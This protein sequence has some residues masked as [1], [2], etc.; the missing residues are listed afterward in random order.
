MQALGR[1]EGELTD[2]R[3]DGADADG[4]PGRLLLTR[5]EIGGRAELATSKEVTGG[6][7]WR[8]LHCNLQ[9]SIHARAAPSRCHAGAGD[10]DRKDDR[11]PRQVG[12]ASVAPS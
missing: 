11:M 3:A 5:R 1:Q 10:G 7:R 8:D 12:N 4:R 6:G 2:G 9:V